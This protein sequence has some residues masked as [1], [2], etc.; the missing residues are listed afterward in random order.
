MRPIYQRNIPIVFS[1]ACERHG[2]ER[3][4]YARLVGIDWLMG[5]KYW[6][7]GGGDGGDDEKVHDQGGG[8]FSKLD[9]FSFIWILE[10]LLLSFA[11]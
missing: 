7:G 6:C 10:L 1:I 8:E 11:H 4:I 9:F 2:C 5:T 3:R